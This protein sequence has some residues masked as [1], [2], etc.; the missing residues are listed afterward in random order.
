MDLEKLT[1]SKKKCHKIHVG[2]HHRECSELYVNGDV[3]SESKSEK[4][5]GDIIHSSG[6]IKPKFANKM[7]KAWGR[8]S[9]IL[10]IVK[11]ASLGR[12]KIMSGLIL[13]KALLHNTIL[14]I[15][16]YIWIQNCTGVQQ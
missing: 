3:M 1:L 13:K 9:E 14:Y 8:V 7:S 6:S 2:K 5:L 11:E 12:H 4:Y 10:A 15:Y 16:I